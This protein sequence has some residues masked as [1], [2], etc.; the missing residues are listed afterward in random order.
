[1]EEIKIKRLT[2]KDIIAGVEIFDLKVGVYEGKAF[3]LLGKYEDTGLTPAEV[4]ELAQAKEDG[5]LV[6]LPCKVGTEIYVTIDYPAYYN[7]VEKTTITG[8]SKFLHTDG[9]MPTQINTSMCLCFLWEHDFNKTIFL[10]KAE[11]QAAL[12]RMEGQE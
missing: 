11:A 6:E 1:M 2:A 3:N 10:A 9:T 8:V 12:D 7:P 4:A 5:R